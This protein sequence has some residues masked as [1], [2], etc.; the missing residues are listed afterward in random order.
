MS[1]GH[2]LLPMHGL[3]ALSDVLGRAE[4]ALSAPA[5]RS[6]RV[7]PEAAPVGMA[8]MVSGAASSERCRSP[9]LARL[10]CW[11]RAPGSA[12]AVV[13]LPGH[14][15]RRPLRVALSGSRTLGMSCMACASA[16]GIAAGKNLLRSNSLR[17]AR[18][19]WPAHRPPADRLRFVACLPAMMR[20]PHASFTA[21]L[22]RSLLGSLPVWP[23]RTR[24]RALLAACWSK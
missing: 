15:L 17:L 24:A 6:L 11:C 8:G 20:C 14:R 4:P 5:F 19:G 7:G 10:S 9:T 1:F 23:S 2:I 18:F 3:K 12:M 13:V 16:R 22:L 21:H